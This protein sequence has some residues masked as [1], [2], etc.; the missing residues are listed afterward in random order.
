MW[1]PILELNAAEKKLLALLRHE[2]DNDKDSHDDKVRLV[3]HHVSYSRVINSR[4]NIKATKTCCCG[5]WYVLLFDVQLHHLNRVRIIKQPNTKMCFF[6]VMTVYFYYFMRHISHMPQT[7]FQRWITEFL[8]EWRIVTRNG[9]KTKSNF[10]FFQLTAASAYILFDTLKHWCNCCTA[11]AKHL[12]LSIVLKTWT[13]ELARQWDRYMNFY[14][15][16]QK[17]PPWR[18]AAIFPKQLGIF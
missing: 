3:L 10:T 14:S 6:S 5:F 12:E 7:F 1:K 17:N 15:V 4:Q 18:L 9:T 2:I 16:S 13:E 8:L 11:F